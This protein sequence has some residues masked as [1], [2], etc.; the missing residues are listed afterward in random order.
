MWMP[1]SNRHTRCQG[2]ILRDHHLLLIKHQ[3]HA[4]VRTYWVLPGG[5]LEDGETEEQCVCREMKEETNLDVVVGAHI[6]DE[7]GPP[8]GVYHWVKTYLCDPGE[9]NASP[10]YEPELEAAANYS[11]IAIRWFDLRD[12][13]SWDPVL[14]K[15][16]FTFPLVQRIRTKLS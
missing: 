13:K 14:V 1:V 9:G 11:I 12:D 3:S 2:A 4:D 10:G 15:D 8:D 16:P 5:G 6:L 7:P